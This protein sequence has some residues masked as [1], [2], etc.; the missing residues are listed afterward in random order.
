MES[1][2]KIIKRSWKKTD[3]AYRALQ[4]YQATPLENGYSPAEL[5][6]GR[7]IRTS[8]PTIGCSLKPAIPNHKLLK[9]WE[10]NNKAKEKMNFDRRHGTRPLKPL[11]T[12][13]RVWISDQR[14]TGHITSPSNAPRSYLVETDRG[15]IR[16]NRLHLVPVPAPSSSEYAVPQG[17]PPA[18]E[19]TAFIPTSMGLP[20]TR[21]GRSVKPV[22][23]L[24]F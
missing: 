8:L 13:Q 5:L 4:A 10:E 17:P 16:R 21:S 22:N 6:M 12:G 2:V 14:Q 19:I 1:A 20:I 18:S 3:D 15:V 9:K 23:R 7:R 11:Q 24:G